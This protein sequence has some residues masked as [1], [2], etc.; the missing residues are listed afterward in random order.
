MPIA[1]PFLH[2]E[3][4]SPQ[5]PYSYE[6]QYKDNSQPTYTP[7]VLKD[8]FRPK[9]RLPTG[10]TPSAA[11]MCNLSLPDS[12]IGGIIIRSNTYTKARTKL[13]ETILVD[14]VMKRNSRWMHPNKY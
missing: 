2:I 14:R 8:Q 9:F 1:T 6:V 5:R 4:Y 12:I 10:V 13:D 3:T 7:F 11:A